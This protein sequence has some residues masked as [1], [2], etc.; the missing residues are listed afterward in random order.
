MFLFDRT[1]RLVVGEAGKKGL[2][3]APPFHIEFSVEKT[4]K[5]DP[6]K[7]Q[8]KIYNL[9]PDTRRALEKPDAFAVLY[10]G[11]GENAGA[12][13]LA[14]GAVI[15]CITVFDGQNVVTALEL[16]DGWVELRDCYVSLGYAAGVSAH[17]VI[18]D[19]ARQM[20]LVLEMAADLPDH[21]WQHG[22]SH[23]GAARI[24]LGKATAAAGLAWS[25]Q[26][27]VLRVV[28]KHGTTPR[29]AVVL[30]ADSGLVGF[31][32]RFAQAATG[33]AAKGKGE[34]GAVEKKRYGWKVKSLL[35]PQVNPS[36]VLKL[37]S[38]QVNGFFRVE[39]VKHSGGFD[40]GDWVSEF[41]LF[42]LNEPPPAAKQ[43]NKK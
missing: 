20:G 37:E 3:I 16:A 11:Y 40:G 34:K 22:F 33:K 39:S 30:A 35:L 1:Y 26:N 4:A 17:A 7:C 24:A 21:V 12:V 28:K 19:I 6:N 32:E 38:K 27:Q 25:I 31:P 36:D 10:A 8:V 5:E 18:R 13:V 2:E 43:V 41:E 23:H 15:E 42:D 29:R 9:K 14:A